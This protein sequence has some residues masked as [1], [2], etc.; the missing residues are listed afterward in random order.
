MSERL[1]ICVVDDDHGLRLSLED[2]L[3]GAG[4]DSGLYAS[5]EAF[6]DSPQ[7]DTCDC[8]ISDLRMP[9]MGGLEMLRRLRARR[10]VPVVM[11][12]AHATPALHDVAL[13]C[14]AACLLRKPFR[15]DALLAAMQAAMAG[16][17]RGPDRD[18]DPRPG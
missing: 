6:L 12:S 14:G 13:R 8:V 5:A 17:G 3:L 9:G 11:I 4:H 10:A 15:P 18:R 16:P 1:L 7:C 2:L